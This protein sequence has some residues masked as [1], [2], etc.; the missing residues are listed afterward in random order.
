MTRT[1]ECVSWVEEPEK[2]KG[3]I[4]LDKYN[5]TSQLTLSKKGYKDAHKVAFRYKR[6]PLRFLSL[7]FFIY[8]FLYD[9]GPKSF[10]YE[11]FFFT[12]FKT[13]SKVFMSFSFYKMFP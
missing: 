8:P 10:K 9:R 13:I 7:V 3:K 1:E 5:T 11:N 2:K 6:S 4:L 12:Y